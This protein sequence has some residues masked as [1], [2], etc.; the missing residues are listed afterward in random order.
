LLKTLEDGRYL[1][2]LPT[3]EQYEFVASDGGRKKYGTETGTIFGADGRRLAH[4][5]E[6]NEGLGTTVS[7]DDPKYFQRLPF[8]GVQ[9]VGNVWR[10]IRWKGQIFHLLG[11]S[12]RDIQRHLR[13][14]SWSSVVEDGRA[15]FRLG[16]NPDSRYSG[17]G[18]QPV[19]VRIGHDQN[20]DKGME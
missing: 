20:Q 18:F 19:A 13:G 14:G 15:I 17:F 7:V 5:G 8:G 16:V 3:D 11:E 6:Y 10:W 4:I 12:H 9:T 2:D 1:Y